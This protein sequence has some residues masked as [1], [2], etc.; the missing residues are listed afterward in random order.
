MIHHLVLKRTDFGGRGEESPLD[1]AE[2]KVRGK[3]RVVKCPFHPDQTPSLWVNLEKLCFHCFSC[4]AKG[5]VTAAG[6]GRLPTL[7]L[8]RDQ[9]AKVPQKDEERHRVLRDAMTFFQL[10]LSTGVEYL[11]SR[12]VDLELARSLGCGYCPDDLE[13][14][15]AFMRERGWDGLGSLVRHSLV[16]RSQAGRWT[17]SMK[18]RVVFPLTYEGQFSNLAGR[19]VRDLGSSLKWLFL[20]NVGD[21]P[22]GVFGEKSLAGSRVILTESV[23]DALPWLELGRPALALMGVAIPGW[24]LERLKGKEVYF[25]LNG[26]EAGNVA[27][28]N[29]LERLQKSAKEIRWIHLPEGYKDW[30]EYHC[31]RRRALGMV[32]AI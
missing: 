14:F 4:E 19:R 28:R 25:A 5:V 7:L 23:F 15:V 30:N 20:K 13:S 10:H 29:H 22:K 31:D 8:R 27:T 32:E 17:L 26:D 16:R 9:V 2:A 12:M 18:G 11:R 3:E 21:L 6:S 1:L 24:L